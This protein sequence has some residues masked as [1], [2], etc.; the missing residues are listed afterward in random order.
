LD[1]ADSA[2]R[3]EVLRRRRE[4]LTSAET[5][6][7]VLKPNRTIAQTSPRVSPRHEVPTRS[8]RSVPVSET[9]QVRIGPRYVPQHF[10]LRCQAFR[11]APPF[12]GCG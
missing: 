2:Q 7:P 9:S 3:C 8:A 1:R 12:R 5:A 11:F 10:F 6:V 4:L